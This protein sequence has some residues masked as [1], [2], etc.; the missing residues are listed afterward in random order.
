MSDSDELHRFLFERLGIRGE[1]VR[2]GTAWRNIR[3]LQAYPEPVG[4]QLGEALA[5][6]VMLSS[7]LK[8]QGS[9]ILQLQGTGPVH[10]VVAQS[11]HDRAIR[12][13]ARWHPE[14]EAALQGSAVPFAEL[15]GSGRLVMTLYN[16]GSEPYQGIVAIEGDSVAASI[17]SYFRQSEQLATRLWLAADEQHAAGLF[18]QELPREGGLAIDWERVALLAGT[19]TT[20]E[21]LDLDTETLCRRLFHEQALRLFEP[22]P[23]RFA[24]GC[25]RERISLT[26]R[27]LGEAEL[28]AA[29]GDSQN[30]T[31][32]CEFCGRRYVFDAVD[33]GAI[34]HGADS[35]DPPMPQ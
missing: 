21:L 14:A 27:L 6:V 24:C 28:T 17:E 18:L 3:A 15:L 10:T 30:I 31:V 8:Y 23:V 4:R 32:D 25:S 13:L 34:L 16:E 26:L 1:R 35:L 11:T 19:V 22:E 33:L 2:L 7:T 9:L 5:G 12:G 20:R 29:Q